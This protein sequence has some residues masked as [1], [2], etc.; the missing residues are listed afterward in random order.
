M[1]GKP[2]FRTLRQFDSLNT[3][4]KMSQWIDKTMFSAGMQAADKDCDNVRFMI[5]ETPGNAGC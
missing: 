4:Q 1:M 5:Q 2:V 3:E